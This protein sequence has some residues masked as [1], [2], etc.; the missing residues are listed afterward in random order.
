MI[1]LMAQLYMDFAC[2]WG[3]AQSVTCFMGGG[4]SLLVWYSGI[5]RLILFNIL[6][7]P[8]NTTEGLQS[9]PVRHM[10]SRCTIPIP[11]REPSPT[12]SRI[13]AASS[14]ADH[15]HKHPLLAPLHRRRRHHSRSG[16]SRF[17]THNRCRST[18]RL[19]LELDDCSD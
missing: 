6:M 15:P 10:S 18:P 12:M 9:A 2:V 11:H 16:L 19:I 13:R 3:P 4:N 5:P 1:V 8:H 14:S 17:Q 7:G